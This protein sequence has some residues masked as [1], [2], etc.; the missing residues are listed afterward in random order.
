[1]PLY[2]VWREMNR[3]CYSKECCNY[4]KYGALG[5]GVCDEWKRDC[6]GGHNGFINFLK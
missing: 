4:Y 1:M 2:S 6:D 5:I 3:R